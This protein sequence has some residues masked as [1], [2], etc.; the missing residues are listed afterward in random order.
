MSRFTPESGPLGP[1]QTL[2]WVTVM[3]GVSLATLLTHVVEHAKAGH[4]RLVGG[5]AVFAAQLL[6][7]GL[8][9]VGRP[10]VEGKRPPGT[11]AILQKPW[12]KTPRTK[13]TEA[14]KE[15]DV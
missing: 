4:M 13:A 15:L 3:L 12:S 8:V 2:V 6:G 11:A 14:I 5:P 7:Y 10:V 9:W 1:H